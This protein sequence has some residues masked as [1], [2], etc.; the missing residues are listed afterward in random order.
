VLTFPW[1]FPAIVENFESKHRPLASN[2]YW[3]VFVK[4][5]GAEVDFNN[6][7]R[8]FHQFS[9]LF[10]PKGIDRVCEG[11]LATAVNQSVQRIHFHGLDI[12]MANLT[13]HQPSIKVLKCE[14][15]HGLNVERSLNG[16][17]ADWSKQ[18]SSVLGAT[19]NYYTPSDDQRSFLD[20][21]EVNR[22]PYCIAVTALIESPMKMFVQ[23]QNYSKVL[24]GS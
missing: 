15:S 1:N 18:E 21:L 7:F 17:E 14:I 5:S 9:A 11:K 20:N 10:D 16:V 4:N 6:L 13:V 3:S 19:A 23:N 24:F 8:E 12:E 22:K 2:N